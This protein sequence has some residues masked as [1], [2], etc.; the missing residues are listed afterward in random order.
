VGVRPVRSSGG[1]RL[2]RLAFDRHAAVG[3]RS[4]EAHAEHILKPAAPC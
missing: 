4:I 2:R 1:D 3:T